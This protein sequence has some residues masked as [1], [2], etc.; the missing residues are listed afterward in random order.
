M[1]VSFVNHISDDDL[2][3]FLSDIERSMKDTGVVRSF[4]SHR[5]V[6]TPGEDSIPAFIATAVLNFTVDTRDDLAALFAAPGA[7]D[8]IHKWQSD[9]PYKVAWVNYQSDK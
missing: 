6:P 2:Y 3:Q 5:H 7:I 8:I 1:L 4:T 9:H